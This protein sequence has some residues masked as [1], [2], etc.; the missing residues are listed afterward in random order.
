MKKLQILS[1]LP[2]LALASCSKDNY[3]GTYQFR[4]GKTDGSHLEMTA[5]LSNEKYDDNGM[6][7]MTLSADLGEEMSPSSIIEKYGEQYPIIEPFVDIIIDEIKDINEIPLYYKV[8]DSA[9]EK[10]GNRLAIGTDFVVQKMNEV[11]EKYE[12]V[13]DILDGL[14]IDDSKFALTPEQTKYFFS[15][16]VNSKS[17]TFEI[18][19]SMDDLQMQTFWYGKSTVI[20]DDYIDKLPGVKG[21]ERF[22]THPIIKKDDKGNI[23]KNECDEVNK[24]FE[25]EFSNTHLYVEDAEGYSTKIGSFVVEEIDGKQTL[26]CY[27]ESSYAGSHSNI[28]G[29]VYVNNGLGDFDSKETI[30]I[31]VNDDN[32][33][34]VTYKEESGKHE[35]FVD[36]NGKEFK[37]SSVIQAPFVFRDFH[38]VNLGL[39]KI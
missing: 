19:V 23:I 32:T 16:Y 3:A 13:K 10:Y 24:T 21:E 26:K 4:L 33:T 12:A 20:I 11:K 14:G 36:E 9:V 8:L 5:V 31:S 27:L 25:K 38:T 6:K 7:K 28:E 39:A 37:F 15:A 18:P 2:I 17:L 29:F 35:G 1:I 30:K 22:G 34:S